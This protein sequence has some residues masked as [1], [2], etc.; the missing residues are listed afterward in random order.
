[1]QQRQRAGTFQ[2][3]E[4]GQGLQLCPRNVVSLLRRHM[5]LDF[6]LEAILRE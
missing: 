2:D 1:M 4:R 6:K 5:Y 3:V